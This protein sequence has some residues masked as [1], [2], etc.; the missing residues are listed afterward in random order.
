MVKYVDGPLAAGLSVSLALGEVDS[1]RQTATGLA[2][3]EYNT[4]TAAVRAQLAYRFQF[5]SVDVV[6]SIAGSLTYLD[7]DDF[8]EGGAG[9][10]NATQIGSDETIAGVHAA[11]SA[12]TDLV[13]GPFDTLVRPYVTLGVDW[14]N[15]PSFSVVST[16]GPNTF[17]NTLEA[18]DVVGRIS[19]GAEIFAY[20]DVVVTVAYDGG[21]G[22]N[23][24]SHAGSA[25]LSLNF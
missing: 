20:H 10:N 2:V 1:D 24:T 25:K 3:G 23:T 11:V 13:L 6:P 18:D 21:F 9:V 14:Y 8:T 12:S 5:G 7:A 15:D 22:S 19:L 17:T 4:F 16:V